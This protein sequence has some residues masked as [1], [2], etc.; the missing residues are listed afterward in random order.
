MARFAILAL[1]GCAA[2][3][4]ATLK[5]D[6][7][8][9]IVGVINL[10]E[11]LQVQ[12]KEDGEA[13]ASTYQKY[14][15]W[16]TNVE[17]ALNKAIT[18]HKS[19]IDKLSSTIEGDEK[20]VLTLKRNIAKLDKELT[21]R[22]GQLDKATTKREEDAASYDEDQADFTDTIDTMKKLIT[23]MDALE[24]ANA[25]ANAASFLQEKQAALMKHATKLL[26]SLA[27]EDNQRSA[28]ESLAAPGT[29][30]VESQMGN[31]KDL[32]KAMMADFQKKQ[33]ESI[34]EETEAKNAYNLMKQAQDY[35][36]SEAEESKS[37]KEEILGDRSSDLAEHQGALSDEEAGLKSESENLDNHNADCQT[38][39]DEWAGRSKHRT[40][41]IEALSQAVKILQEVS[42]VRNPDTHEIPKHPPYGLTQESE[43]D[44][45]DSDDDVS[46]LQKSEDPAKKA[47]NVLRMVLKK[48]KS[49]SLAK[50]VDTISAMVASKGPFDKMKGMIGKM[51]FRL[52]AEQKDEDDHKKWCDMELTKSTD[53]RDEKDEK[54]EMLNAKIAAANA[55]IA[56]LTEKIAENDE[57]VANIEMYIQEETDLR[58][59]NNA[60]NLATIKDAKD[61][62]DAVDKAILVLTK[63]YKSTGQ[64]AK[65]PYEFVQK[66]ASKHTVSQHRA[67]DIDLPES[68]ST[69]DAEY[70]GVADPEAEG[71][72]VIAILTATGESFATLEVD[73]KASEES[74]E[75]SFQEDMASQ[76]A[77]KAEKQQDTQ[78]K[79]NRRT[80]MSQKLDSLSTNKKH[81]TSEL[82]AVNNYLT[83]LQPACVSG[84][85][86]YEDRKAARMDEVAALRKAQSI[87][88]DAFSGAFLQKKK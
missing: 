59:A 73:A 17:K 63:F 2:A 79:S 78:M 82:D 77:D 50:L 41:E 61:G 3:H 46:F 62:K 35:A 81:L 37:T 31:V 49:K 39:A 30:K 71:S 36:I 44:D 76:K 56:E 53:S 60:E 40:G 54:M 20:D 14:T 58:N 15:Y 38:K 69:W 19:E 43:T 87:L 47:L 52:M 86:S 51:V 32:I 74:D 6:G 9:P 67:G 84:D 80:S 57:A 1:L 65:A 42:G 29:Q 64:I 11:D 23:A 10:L 34:K 33:A 85:S 75:K 83:D 66:A 25:D 55:A 26:Q 24:G 45:D 48:R 70:T 68:P 88:E 27:L 72:G 7:E 16:C 8:H 5:V 21:R 12:A 22:N 13:E 18:G 4:A 28:L